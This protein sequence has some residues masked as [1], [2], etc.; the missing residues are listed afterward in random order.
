MSTDSSK[1]QILKELTNVGL[2]L[3][4]SAIRNVS[5]LAK[6]ITLLAIAQARKDIRTD[7]IDLTLWTEEQNNVL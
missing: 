4:N 1:E 6:R 3:R 5:P 2:F 7:K